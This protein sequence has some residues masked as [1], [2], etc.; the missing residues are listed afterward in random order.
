[1]VSFFDPKRKSRLYQ[2]DGRWSLTTLRQKLM[3]IGAKVVR[4]GRNI[5]FQMA[6]VAIPKPKFAEILHLI[7]GLRPAPLPLWRALVETHPDRPTGQVC[8]AQVEVR[9]H[10]AKWSR[11]RVAHRPISPI[12]SGPRP[13]VPVQGRIRGRM[14][15]VLTM[16]ATGR[17]HLGNLG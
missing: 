14:H 6:E 12:K 9:L 16:S 11:G 5:T 3:K 8:A 15:I 2:Q 13:I 10:S 17:S 7:V 1:M 4:H